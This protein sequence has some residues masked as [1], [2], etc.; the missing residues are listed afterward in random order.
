M[1]AVARALSLSADVETPLTSRSYLRRRPFRHKAR[2]PQVRTQSFTAQPPDLRCRPLT[3]RASRL[4]ARSP[5]SASSCI[6]FLSVGSR[7]R[8]TLPPHT[9]SPS[10]SCASLRSL[11]SAYGGTSARKIAPMLGA[12]AQA[13][14]VSGPGRFRLLFGSR[15]DHGRVQHRYVPM[16][17]QLDRLLRG[18]GSGGDFGFPECVAHAGPVF[19]TSSG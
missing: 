2:S 17:P 5:W 15:L 13:P 6:R 4:H 9:R 16:G 18:G 8:S 1:I 3:T 14:L 11:W 7:L 12:H 19:G 10:C